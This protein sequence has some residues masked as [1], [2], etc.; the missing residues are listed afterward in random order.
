MSV[1]LNEK[2]EALLLANWATIMDKTRLLKVVLE[3]ARNTEY[4]TLEQAQLPPR[5]TKVQVT[6]FRPDGCKFSVWVEFT[7]P[8]GEGVVVGTHVYSLNL[9]GELILL[10]TFGSHFCQKL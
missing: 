6:K 7:V 2:L 9:D 3:H 8:K 1:I 4:S 10:E 5:H